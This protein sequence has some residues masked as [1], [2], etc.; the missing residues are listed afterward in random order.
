MQ[1][2]QVFEL[3]EKDPLQHAKYLSKDEGLKINTQET[4]LPLNHG[5]HQLPAMN[6][7]LAVFAF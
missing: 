5:Y 4:G 7:V 2:L 1:M 6:I 3:P